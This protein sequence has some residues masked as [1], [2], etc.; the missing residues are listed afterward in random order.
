[1]IFTPVILAVLTTAAELSTAL[2]KGLV[3]TEFAFNA[4]VL[5][6]CRADDRDFAVEDKAVTVTLPKPDILYH[7]LDEKSFQSYDIKNSVFTSTDIGGYADMISALKERQ[8]QK[9]HWPERRP[10]RELP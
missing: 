10:R 5:S 3:G 9:R 4:T 8:E 6:E 7:E 1:M 2:Q